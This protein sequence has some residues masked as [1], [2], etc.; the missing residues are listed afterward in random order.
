MRIAIVDAS[1]SGPDNLVAGLQDAGHSVVTVLHAEDLT[2]SA[3]RLTESLGDVEAVVLVPDGSHTALVVDA[4]QLAGILRLVLL[5]D[6]PVARQIAH[7]SAL[8]VSVV[9]PGADATGEAAAALG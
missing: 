3:T 6:D 8:E 2:S 7:D 9:A 1:A 4:A 5:T